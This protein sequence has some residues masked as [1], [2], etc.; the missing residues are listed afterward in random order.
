MKSLRLTLTDTRFHVTPDELTAVLAAIPAR[1]TYMRDYARGRYR[2]SGADLRGKANR[3]GAVYNRSRE[4]VHTIAT[5]VLGESL[6]SVTGYRCAKSV[7]SVS[8][9]GQEVGA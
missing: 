2:V 4:R 7:W 3:Y 5:A 9:L 8:A 1:Y 6:V